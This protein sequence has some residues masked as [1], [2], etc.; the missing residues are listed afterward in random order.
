MVITTQTEILLHTDPIFRDRLD[1][2]AYLLATSCLYFKEHPISTL[3]RAFEQNEL[4]IKFLFDD[5]EMTSDDFLYSFG[6]CDIG[7]ESDPALSETLWCLLLYI[8]EM[9]YRFGYEL[10]DIN[11]LFNNN[12]GWEYLACSGRHL[13]YEGAYG[14]ARRI[15]SFILSWQK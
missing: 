12:Y 10:E 9:S 2:L 4:I 6:S 13:C 8:L 15:N 3:K 5:V 1:K 11:D 14:G 7:I